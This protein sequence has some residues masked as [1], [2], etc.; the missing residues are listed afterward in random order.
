MTTRII[1]ISDLHLPAREQWQTE[2]L[3]AAINGARPDLVVVSGDL[4]RAGSRSEYAEAEKLLGAIPGRK[5][6]VPGN[7]DIPVLN[8]RER[9]LAPFRRFENSFGTRT[10][11]FENDDV[12]L[13]GLNTAYG[14][15]LSADWSLGHARKDKIERAADTIRTRKNGRLAA[16]ICHHPLLQN[17]F[18]PRRSRTA[19]GREAFLLLADAGMDIVLHGHLHRVASECLSHDGREVCQIG[20]NTALSDRERDGGS[21][22]NLLE[23]EDGRWALSSFV[24]HNREYVSEPARDGAGQPIGIPEAAS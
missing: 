6:V 17:P 20:A 23:I 3:L 13:V 11:I 10:P 18:D 12:L 21:G 14:I 24:W 8:I 16:I 7:H 19:G 2:A 5:L 1:H 15:N 4:T 9:I 22:F